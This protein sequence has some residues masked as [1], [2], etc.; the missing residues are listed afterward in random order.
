V[1]HS[2]WGLSSAELASSDWTAC[3]DVARRAREAGYEAIRY[4]SASGTGENLAIFLDR[5]SPGSSVHIVNEDE[6]RPD[7]W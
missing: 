4:T 5:L 3:Q 7:Q 1:V 6:L 2:S